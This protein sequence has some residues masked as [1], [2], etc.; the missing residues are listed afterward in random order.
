LCAALSFMLAAC[1]GGGGDGNAGLTT[2]GATS[3]GPTAAG[4]Q[5]TGAIQSR[6]T[7]RLYTY[8]IYVPP[9]YGPASSPLPVIYATDAQYQCQDLVDLAHRYSLNA[10]VVAVNYVDANERYADFT[11]PG[12]QSYYRFLTEELIPEVEAQYRVDPK[13]RTLVGY[14]LSGSF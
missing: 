3:A 9:Q 12:A 7:G 13:Q 2:G 14:S 10:L 5:T 1:G 4:T 11:F 8:S 6:I